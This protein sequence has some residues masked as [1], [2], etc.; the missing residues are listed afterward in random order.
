MNAPTYKLSKHLVKLLNTHLTLKIYYSVTNP[1]KLATELT[2]LVIN[3]YYR[4]ITY[5]IKYNF[6]NIPIEDVRGTTKSVANKE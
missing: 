3:K 2:H 6:V 5:D 1:I 4:L